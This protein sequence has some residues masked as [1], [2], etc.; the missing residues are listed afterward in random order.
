[1]MLP[2]G[3]EGDCDTGMGGR[4]CSLISPDAQT[5]LGGYFS[6]APCYASNSPVRLWRI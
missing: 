4:D 2:K 5:G 1:M 6:F 3:D